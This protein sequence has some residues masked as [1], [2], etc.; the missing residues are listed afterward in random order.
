MWRFNAWVKD[1]LEPVMEELHEMPA[2]RMAFHIRGGDKLSEDVQL[3]R[4]IASHYRATK[5]S[6]ICMQ[7]H[8][9][10]TQGLTLVYSALELQDIMWQQLQRSAIPGERYNS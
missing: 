3:V 10:F 5:P 8:F 4:L 2:P 9:C 1:Q 6:L 7:S